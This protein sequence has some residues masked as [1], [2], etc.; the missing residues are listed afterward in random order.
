MWSDTDEYP[1]FAKLFDDEPKGL[2]GHAEL[3]VFFVTFGPMDQLEL[4]KGPRKRNRKD[5][6]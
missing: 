3:R 4:V 6:K 5:D 1:A 2:H